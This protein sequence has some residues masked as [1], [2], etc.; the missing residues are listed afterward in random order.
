[1][2]LAQLKQQ[3]RQEIAFSFSRGDTMTREAVKERGRQCLKKLDRDARKLLAGEDDESIL[4]GFCN[5]LMGFGPLQALL[6]DPDVTEIMVNG[7]N[8]IYVERGGHKTPT[9]ITFSNAGHLRTIVEKMM[10][11]TAR[12]LDESVPFADFALPDGSRVNVI[13]PPLAVGGAMVTIRKFLDTIKNVDHLVRYGTLDQRMAQFLVAAIRAKKNILFSGATGCGKT[14]TLGAL[15]SYLNESERIVV[16]EDTIELELNQ[17]HTVRLL[18]RPPNI[19]NK[20]EVTLRDLLRNSLRMRPSRIILGEIRSAEAMDYL[21]ALNSGHRG[22]LAVM[23][24]ATPR[25]TV[26]RLETLALFAGLNLP[27]FAIRQ[28]IASGLDIIVQQEQLHDGSRKVSHITEVRG[29]EG[30]Q[31]VLQDLFRFEIERTDEQGKVHG[32]F[33]A[34]GKPRDLDLY[35]RKG[36]PVDDAWF[37][38][39]VGG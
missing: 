12:R 31:V 13:I 9:T 24:A 2:D 3:I 19:E 16:I 25:D 36:I 7:P 20:G 14:T 29:T 8:E 23:H 22:C 34:C 30:D 10:E 35:R 15:S 32:S 17:R 38:P 39:L 6:A 28:Q 4:E 27:V 1:M 33:I 11:G 21:Q 5:D 18:T 26:S 37:E